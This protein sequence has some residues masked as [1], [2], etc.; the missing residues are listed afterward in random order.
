MKF[1]AVT[2][3]VFFLTPLLA[4]TAYAQNEPGVPQKLIDKV[5]EVPECSVSPKEAADSVE[6]ADLGKGLKLVTILCWRAAYNFGSVLF[7]LNPAAQR[8]LAC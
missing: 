3:L 1:S 4:L 8:T 2:M 6:L 5:L 7:A